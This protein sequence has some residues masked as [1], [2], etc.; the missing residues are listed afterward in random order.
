MYDRTSTSCKTYGCLNNAEVTLHGYW[1]GTPVYLTDYMV[2]RVYDFS[3]LDT[4]AGD[5][6][7]LFGVRPVIT[8]PKSSIS[9]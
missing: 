9:N 4:S 2:W 5:T 6:N 1:T 8:I 3:N 7:I